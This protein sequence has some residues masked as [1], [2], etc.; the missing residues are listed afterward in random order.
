MRLTLQMLAELQEIKIFFALV[1]NPD[2]VA[3]KYFNHKLMHLAEKN[4]T[5]R[6]L[7]TQF[8]IYAILHE[9][10]DFD[11]QALMSRYVVSNRF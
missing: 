10:Y 2:S 8:S 3:P 1:T 9:H 4:V 5:R 11:T 6:N 7:C